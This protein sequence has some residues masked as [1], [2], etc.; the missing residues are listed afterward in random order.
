MS[1][2]EGPTLPGAP[3][4]ITTIRPTSGWPPLRAGEVWHYRELL[5]FF[6]WRNLKIRYR[7]TAIGTAW[8]L[9]QPLALV[10]IFSLILGRVPGLAPEGISYALFALAAIVPWTFMAHGVDG[11]AM[12]VVEAANMVQKVYFPRL[13]LPVASVVSFLL[14]FAIGMALL[15]VLVVLGGYGVS[16]AWLWLIPLALL[17]TLVAIGTGLWLAAINVRYRDVK[18]AVPFLIQLWFF[19][20]PV[21]YSAEIVPEELWLPYHLNPMAGIV[22]AVRWVLYS[23]SAPAPVAEIALATVTTVVVLVTGQAYFRHTERTF[24]DVI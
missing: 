16:L 9:L 6:V 17:V 2:V 19:A 21:V 10:G 8:A 12:S 14:D 22:E 13:L 7:Q 24:A 15:A 5:Y 11:A 3:V 20:T 23:P 1:T 4:Q 18:H